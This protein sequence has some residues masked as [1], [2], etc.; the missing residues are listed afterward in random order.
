[1]E[2]LFQKNTFARVAPT[3]VIRALTGLSIYPAQHFSVTSATSVHSVLLQL[4][5]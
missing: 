1:M 2:L 3:F 4:S 5:E